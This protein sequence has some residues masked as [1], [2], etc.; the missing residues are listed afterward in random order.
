MEGNEGK[1]ERQ[2]QSEFLNEDET[3]AFFH[4]QGI[5][6]LQSEDWQPGQPILYVFPERWQT[7]EDIFPDLPLGKRPTVARMANPTSISFNETITTDGGDIAYTLYDKGKV[8]DYF[9]ID[10]KTMRPNLVRTSDRNEAREFRYSVRS[11]GLFPANDELFPP[12][13]PA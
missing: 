11:K 6:P 8:V 5:G 13:D 4:E 1:V 7:N 12:S 3:L 2:K 9:V 10:S